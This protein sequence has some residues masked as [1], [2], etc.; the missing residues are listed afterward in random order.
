MPVV[1]F[2]VHES[3]VALWEIGSNIRYIIMMGGRGNGRSGSASRYTVSK[4]LGKE[5]V[6]GAIM[7]A[8]REDIRASC[9]GE[10]QDRLTEQNITDQFHITDNDMFIER[11]QNSLRGHGFRAS[12]GSLT[13]RLKSLAGYNFVWIEEAEEIGENEFRTLDDTL[14]TTKGQ[15]VIL[16]TLNTPPKNHW[17]LQKWFDLVPSGI[18]SFY[19]PQLKADITD[20]IFIGGT[21]KEN[22][23]N[24]DEHTIDRYEAYSITNPAYY[25]QVI[26]GLSPEE[27]RGKIFTGWQLID[28]IPPEARLVKFGEDFGWFPDPACVVA[29]WYWNGAY[30]IDEVAYGTELTNEFLAG[31]IKRYGQAITIADSAEPKSIAEQRK[32]GIQVQ[33]A[34]KGKDSVN[35]RI[36][37][38]STK[39]IFVTRKSVN[40]WKSYENYSWAEDKDGK[41][42]GEPDHTWSHCFAPET[43]VHTT[44]GLK[45]IDELVG[46]EGYVYSR[47]GKIERFH[48]VRPTRENT[49]VISL[50]FND[51]GILTVTPDHLLLLPN[52]Q[53]IEAD[54]L[55]LSDMIQSDMYEQNNP[56]WQSIYQIF[57]RE[58][59]QRIH[60]WK[61]MVFTSLYLV[62]SQRRNTKE[63]SYSSQGWQQ[64]EQ[65]FG[66]STIKASSSSSF[67]THDTQTQDVAERMGKTNNAFGKEMAWV[68]RGNKVAQVTWQKN[69][70][71]KSTNRKDLFTLS[72]KLFYN[73]IRKWCKILWAKLFTE[74]QTKT[75]KRIERG[76]RTMTYNMEVENTHCLMANGVIAHNCMDAVSYP[77]A[78][79]HNRQSDIVVYTKPKE[80]HNVAL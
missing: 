63:L 48:S 1:S 32:Y 58:L 41:P 68:K 6:R 74:S 3:H 69:N 31:E 15:I 5:Y 55:S 13:A 35:F 57:W 64:R 37:V 80:K 54:L 10:I 26:K 52:G 19:I 29:V 38:T 21:W 4:L 18:P 14:R 71:K 20:A 8:T 79:M 78:A 49:E 33:G 9:W 30:I 7:R 76:F 50:T 70:G 60:K 42:K 16:L 11:G 45:R 43:L 27:V 65:F 51:G 17:I 72:Q 59:L 66:K 23:P 24:M 12:S 73:S 34:E 75:I 39:K 44:K 25:N 46:K 67:R 40:V 22:K 62:F 53:W 47:D 61:K 2:E 28:G 77:I 56:Q 36:K